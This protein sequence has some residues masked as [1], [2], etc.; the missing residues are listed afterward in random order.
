MF[1][2]VV[3]PCFNLLYVRRSNSFHII[4]NKLKNN[5]MEVEVFFVLALT[6]RSGEDLGFDVQLL[7]GWARSIFLIPALTS[8]YGGEPI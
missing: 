8:W 5:V 7:E 4:I 6:N 3:L 2:L 1:K